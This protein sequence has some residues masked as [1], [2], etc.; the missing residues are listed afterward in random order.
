MICFGRFAELSDGRAGMC[1]QTPVGQG[2]INAN[3]NPEFL[4][5][6]QG[7]LL[8]CAC[9]DDRC[10]EFAFLCYYCNR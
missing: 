7:Q 6:H 1:I 5:S 4:V 3:K 8:V 2:G 10:G 9:T